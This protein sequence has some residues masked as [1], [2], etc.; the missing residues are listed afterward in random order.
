MEVEPCSCEFTTPLQ[1]QH[2]ATLNL[3]PRALQQ[4]SPFRA[5]HF[6]TKGKQTFNGP[7]QIASNAA[8]CGEAYASLQQNSPIGIANLFRMCGVVGGS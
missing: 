4:S 7:Q 6:C 8:L 1:H 3:R 5:K 2:E